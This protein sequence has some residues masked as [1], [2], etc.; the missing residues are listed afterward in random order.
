MKDT[1]LTQAV[2]EVIDLKLKAVDLFIEEFI[3]P[4]AA[5]GNP[6]KL[7]DKPYEEWTPQDFQMLG[8]VYGT[9]EP[10]ELKKLIINK[11]YAKVKT[12]ES[13]V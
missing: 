9:A 11:E 3:E 12:L 8:M 5:V 10:N 7:I 1:S 6:E 4:L 13:E 2:Q